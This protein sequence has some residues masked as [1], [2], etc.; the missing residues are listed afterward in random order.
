MHRKAAEG[1]FWIDKLV[2]PGSKA[3]NL[4]AIAVRVRLAK[5][6]RGLARLPGI[7]LSCGLAGR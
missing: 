4:L 1:S 5:A 3:A 7:A 6:I 2:G